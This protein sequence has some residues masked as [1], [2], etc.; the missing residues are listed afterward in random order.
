MT[1][2]EPLV[3][4]TERGLYCPRGDF[5]IDPWKK[6]PKAVI[7]HAHSDH[8]RSG[9][10]EYLCT[11]AGLHVLRA[12][13]GA[14][15]SIQTLRYGEGVTMGGVKVSLH[16]AGHVLGSAQVRIEYRGQV[17]VV[18]G[19]YKTRPDPTCA[20]FELVKCHC[21]ITESTFGLPIYRWPDPDKV[22]AE[23]NAWW[24]ENRKAGRASVV[25]AYSFGKAQRLLSMADASIG[26]IYVH[27]TVGNMNKQYQESG[28]KLPA[29]NIT[30]G[31]S[32]ML[33]IASVMEKLYG[34]AL[35]ISPPAVAENDWINQFENFSSA[36]ASGWM[37]IRSSRRR[38]PVDRGFVLSDH[39]DWDEL[40]AVISQTGAEQVIV[41]HG[42]V[43]PLVRYL[44]ENRIDATSF[45][46]QYEGE[47]D[48][49]Q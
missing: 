18:S 5:Y 25:F 6:V 39:A 4:N 19:D 41:T 22:A 26:P 11:D 42:Y 43:K 16:S 46:T 49:S 33:P 17:W 12:R 27:E 24:E 14:K 20:P 35:I 8:A 7:T 37:R 23:L 34:S 1:A 3:V 31:T 30:P 15:A 45:T 44:K 38:Q 28:V 47:L 29:C 21:F 32:G 10:S 2:A 13:L 36:F 40:L 48:N 9:S